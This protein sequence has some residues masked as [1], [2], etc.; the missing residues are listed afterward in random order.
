MNMKR[1]GAWLLSILLAIPVTYIIFLLV[2][3][4]FFE[5]GGYTFISI[6]LVAVSF[7]LIMDAVG[8]IGIFDPRGWYLGLFNTS[9][10]MVEGEERA[11]ANYKPIVSREERLKQQKKTT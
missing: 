9:G 2:Q 5:A 1:L 3:I 4:P 6:F 10:P 8:S 11:P 7:L